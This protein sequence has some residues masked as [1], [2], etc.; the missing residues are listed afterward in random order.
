MDS[1]NYTQFSGLQTQKG[2]QQYRSLDN[3]HKH[4]HYYNS[5]FFTTATPTTAIPT[6]TPC[7]FCYSYS[8]W[9]L[10]ERTVFLAAS[11]S[12]ITTCLLPS[13]LSHIPSPAPNASGQFL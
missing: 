6:P 5:P 11:L 8:L 3:T 7:E 4:S 10:L 13:S 1:F 12:H 9:V 2:Q